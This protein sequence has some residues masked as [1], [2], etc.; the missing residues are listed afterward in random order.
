MKIRLTG[1]QDECDRALRILPSCSGWLLLDI[2]GTDGPYPDQLVADL[3]HMDVEV[4]FR[5][6]SP[7]ALRVQRRIQELGYVPSS[8]EPARESAPPRRWSYDWPDP[9]ARP[10]Y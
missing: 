8:A 3:V 10:R 2:I 6:Q 7:T 5:E 1:T 4:Q 9:D